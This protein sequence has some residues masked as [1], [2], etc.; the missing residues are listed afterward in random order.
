MV[1]NS[2]I[3]NKEELRYEIDF[4]DLE[5]KLKHERARLM[6]LCNPHNPA[7]YGAADA[8]RTDTR[9]GSFADKYGVRVVSGRVHREL[10]LDRCCV[11]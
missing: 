4:D 8:R 6:L 11:L 9:G 5:R 1:S 2:L 10:T 7:W 3:Y